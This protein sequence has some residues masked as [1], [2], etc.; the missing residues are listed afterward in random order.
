MLKDLAH[1]IQQKKEIFALQER[2]TDTELEMPKQ[3]FLFQKLYLNVFLFVTAI[4]LLLVT[5]LVIHILC[6]HRKPK[7]LRANP[8]LQQMKEVGAVTTQEPS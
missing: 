7:T 1:Q 8:A 2:H 5:R 3:N 6:K 4:I